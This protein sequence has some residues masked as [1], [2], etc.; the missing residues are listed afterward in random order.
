VL[1]V[2]EGELSSNGLR[3]EA[4]RIDGKPGVQVEPETSVGI[5]M[6][7]DQRSDPSQIIVVQ[8]IVLDGLCQNLLDHESVDVD[9]RKLDQVQGEHADFLVV[10]A[11]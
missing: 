5:D 6:P 7:I 2:A 1:V 8:A 4:G 3:P 10:D 11:V 9:E